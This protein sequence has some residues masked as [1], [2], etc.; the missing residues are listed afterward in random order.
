L[1]FWFSLPICFFIFSN[2]AFAFTPLKPI[3]FI[4][5][6]LVVLKLLWLKIAS[7]TSCVDLPLLKIL[8]LKEVC[9]KNRNDYISFLSACPILEDFHAEP[10]Y[11]HSEK[12]RDEN[13]VPDEGF[14]FLTLSKLVRVCIGSVDGPFN[15]IGKVPYV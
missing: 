5:Q 4:S 1:C 6:T 15:G 13:D 2:L 9:F 7:D 11:I 10:I 8:H 12:N 3:I 14:K